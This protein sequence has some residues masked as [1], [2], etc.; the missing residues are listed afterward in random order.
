MYTSPCIRAVQR[1][2]LVANLRINCKQLFKEPDQNT[3]EHGLTRISDF[4]STYNIIY[5]VIFSIVS[6]VFS[7]LGAVFIS[8]TRP[9]ETNSALPRFNIE[10]TIKLFYQSSGNEM[11][12]SVNPTYLT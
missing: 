2:L 3:P 5:V 1:Q 8:T 10:R 12:R 4:I 6:L 7:I 9:P 11:D